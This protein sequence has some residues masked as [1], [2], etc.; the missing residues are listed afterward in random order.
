MEKQNI[1]PGEN[2]EKPKTKF[3]LIDDHK[4]IVEGS[5]FYFDDI[6]GFTAVECHTV[7]EALEAILEHLPKTLLLDHN[8]TF[9]GAEGLEIARILREKHPD[10]KIY[11]TTINNDEETLG[12]YKKLGISRVGKENLDD[13]KAL[14]KRG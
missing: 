2:I 3:L 10:I 7:K 14:M 4:A 6:D 12:E 13:M 9:G 11:S 8:L 1:N 5:R